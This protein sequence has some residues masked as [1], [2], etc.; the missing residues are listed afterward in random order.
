M[1]ISLAGLTAFYDASVLY[2][3]PL[4]DLLMWLALTDLFRATWSAMVHAEWIRALLSDRP[5]LTREQLERT[6][7]LM[8][9]HVRDALISGFEGLIASLYLPDPK[10]R[11]VLAAAIT[12]RADVI[13]TRNLRH[14]PAAVLSPFGI[15]AQHPDA[16]IVH[17]LDLAPETVADAVRDHR[18]SLRH[19]PKTVEAYLLTLER[20]GLPQTVMALRALAAGI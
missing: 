4:R 12:G 8:D 5:D 20:Q 6:R 17:L 1:G 13:V 11:H 3:A 15:E 9:A 16:F 2:P 19:P 7:A 14:F 18:A 10:D